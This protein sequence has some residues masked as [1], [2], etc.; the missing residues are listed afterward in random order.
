MKKNIKSFASV[1]MIGTLLISNTTYAKSFKDL[2][3]SGDYGWAYS[4]VDNLSNKSILGGYPDGSFKPERP[5]SFLEIMQII[6]NIKNPSDIE[7]QKAKE[8]F[9]PVVKKYK[10]A[11]WAQD[12]VCYALFTNV[13][14]EKTLISA[15]NRG[16]SKDT[17]TV[18][19]NRNSV[20]V[21]F[22]RAFGF[23]GSGKTDNLKH[24]DL[25]NVPNMTKGYLSELVDAKIYS[26]TG[27]DGYFNGNKYIRRA[28][29]AVIS[30][31]AIN[32]LD[33]KKVETPKENYETGDLT[34]GLIEDVKHIE[35]NVDFI[36]LSGEE[37]TIKIDSKEYRI[38]LNNI[39]IKD[40][41]NSYNGDILTLK[42]SK[43]LAEIRNGEVIS[44]EIKNTNDSNINENNESQKDEFEINISG[45]VLGS[46]KDGDTNQIE[47]YVLVSDTSEFV[48]GDTIYVESNKD[49][50]KDQTVSIKGIQVDGEL[51][52]LNIQN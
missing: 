15:S 5:V 45:R 10:V 19:P 52:E 48:A 13:I 24:K 23:S 21:Y 16:F 25:K 4:S 2:N 40:L 42:D 18:Y 30:D 38:K 39:K 35:G 22:G 46:K 49:Y 9:M 31:R 20:T 29:V 33:N 27:S 47:V 17:N 8:A 28:E 43:V 12:S 7:M 1:L 3:K 36:T 6:K 37:S 11:P 51:K 41:N 26:A 14:T 34:T 50:R 32:Y 44:I